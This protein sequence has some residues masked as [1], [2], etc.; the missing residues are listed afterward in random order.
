MQIC[1][2]DIPLK[3]MRLQIRCQCVTPI[4]LPF[5]AGSALR[6][7]FGHALKRICCTARALDDCRSC[8]LRM[9]CC[10]C[11]VFENPAGD[12]ETYLHSANLPHPFV[13]EPPLPGKRTIGSNDHF[14]FGFSAFGRAI[15][16][17]PWFAYA[18]KTMGE[19][20]LGRGRGSFVVQEVIDDCGGIVY[21]ADSQTVRSCA[22]HTSEELTI[23][24]CSDL[25]LRLLTP[26]RIL[27]DERLA[28]KLDFSLL[29][30]NLLRR[31][32]LLADLHCDTPWNIDYAGI[33]GQ[34]E[35]GVKI[36]EQQLEWTDWERYSNR[37]Q[38]RHK[39]GG[40]RG[41][42]RY[43][44]DLEPFDLLL[45]LGEVVH[46]G[47]NTTFGNGQYHLEYNQPKFIRRNHQ[48]AESAERV[49]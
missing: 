45:Q 2:T 21:T 46:I 30:R 38:Q 25:T 32:S 47:K 28:K 44:G 20:G 36:A 41:L 42:I 8:L 12:R 24:S 48:F 40:L 10:Y 1:A 39:L 35:E 31:C 11:T 14:S 34:A 43:C 29:V 9:S 26:V 23:K 37:H 17:L 13:F 49:G 19:T 15:D 33:I 27:S 16:Y 7:A 22:V 18:F 5:F 4:D 3:W 6:G